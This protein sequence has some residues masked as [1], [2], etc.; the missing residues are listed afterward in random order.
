DRDPGRFADPD[1]L[2]LARTDNQH[3]GYGHGIHYSG[4]AGRTAARRTAGLD[5][6]EPPACWGMGTPLAL[7]EQSGAG[8]WCVVVV[9]RDGRGSR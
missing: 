6:C 8:W 2:D 9:C 4:T 3:L 7:V 5:I 1:A